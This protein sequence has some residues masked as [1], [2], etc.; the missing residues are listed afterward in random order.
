M[1][2]EPI[3]S[4][5]QLRIIGTLGFLML[6]IDGDVVNEEKK[7]IELFLRDFWH[8]TFGEY[9]DCLTSIEKIGQSIVNDTGTKVDKID[10]ILKVLNE[11]LTRP[12]KEVVADFARQVMT[13]DDVIDAGEKALY[14]HIQKG[15]GVS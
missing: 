15:L 11:Q 5:P 12:Q 10:R 2:N 8:Y 1:A 13:A 9:R 6:A 4:L 14:F 3:F 7:I